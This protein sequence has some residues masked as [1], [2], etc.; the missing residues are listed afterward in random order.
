MSS[1]FLSDEG[2][3]AFLEA[4]GDRGAIPRATAAALTVAS[5][6]VMEVLTANERANLLNVKPAAV[7]KRFSH[8]H[9]D[10]F[11]PGSLKEYGRRFERALELFKQWNANP[12]NFSVPT[13]LTKRARQGRGAA[14]HT[15]GETRALLD[16]N[17]PAAR[18]GA[19]SFHSSFPVRPGTVVTFLNIPSDL[20]KA[21]AE[22]LA[23]FVRMLAVER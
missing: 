2:L 17:A 10:R 21:E 7:V 15:H 20:T 13:R 3:L 6:R 14:D 19:S 1:A 12:S 4:A 9:A 18:A 23:Q 22:R 11:S 8:K 16:E 5:R